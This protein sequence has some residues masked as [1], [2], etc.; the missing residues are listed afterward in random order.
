[1]TAVPFFAILKVVTTCS[2]VPGSAPHTPLCYLD[3]SVAPLSLAL[4]GYSAGAVHHQAKLV[5][6]PI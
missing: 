6:Q 3:T 5:K 2:L 4:N 1:M